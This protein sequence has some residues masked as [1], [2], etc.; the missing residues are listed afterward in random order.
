[1][2]FLQKSSSYS[3]TVRLSRAPRGRR[4]SGGELKTSIVTSHRHGDA[5]V[6]DGRYIQRRSFVCHFLAARRLAETKDG[7]RRRGTKSNPFDNRSPRELLLAGVAAGAQWGQRVR[8]CPRCCCC[9]LVGEW[10][11]TGGDGRGAESEMPGITC[12]EESISSSFLF[13]FRGKLRL[14]CARTRDLI[15]V[16]R[17]ERRC[18]FSREIAVPVSPRT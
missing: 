6:A 15:S 16:P 5:G 1:M 2:T 8:G 17:R 14:T 18:R 11:K 10:K 3:H 7:V 13:R 12:S 4:V 9:S